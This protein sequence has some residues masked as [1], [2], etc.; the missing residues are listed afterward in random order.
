MLINGVR[1]D[2][3]AYV[4]NKL[5]GETVLFELEGRRNFF[6]TVF[7]YADGQP[8]PVSSS[9]AAECCVTPSRLDP[10]ATKTTITCT[11]GTSGEIIVPIPVALRVA[12]TNLFCE[13]NISGTDNLNRDFR[14]KASSFRLAILE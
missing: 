7:L 11:I 12:G 10:D 8:F 1:C 9:L 5:T 13:I 14:Y 6:V 3:F 2:T 4:D